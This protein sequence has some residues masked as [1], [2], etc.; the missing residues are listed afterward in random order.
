MKRPGGVPEAGEDITSSRL[1]QQADATWP[2]TSESPAQSPV[3]T[4]AEPLAETPERLA[5]NDGRRLTG[6]LDA[7]SDAPHETALSVRKAE[8]PLSLGFPLG[9]AWIRTKDQRI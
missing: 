5:V 6:G 3:G 4:R 9:P 8:S 1:A 2:P 7:P